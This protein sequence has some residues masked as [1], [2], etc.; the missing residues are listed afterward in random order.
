[1][2]SQ[3]RVYYPFVGPFDPCPPILE[4]WYVVPPNVTMPWQ[5]T[6]LQQFSP[7]EALKLGTLWPAYYSPYEGRRG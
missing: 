1:M 3:W 2:K 5:A 7:Q 4:K 6:N